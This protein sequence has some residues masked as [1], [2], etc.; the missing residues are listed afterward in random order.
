MGDLFNEFKT[1]DKKVYGKGDEYNFD[2]KVESLKT[3]N[4]DRDDMKAIEQLVQILAYVP[5]DKLNLAS[6]II[7][8]VE[9]KTCIR[10]TDITGMRDYYSGDDA[11]LTIQAEN[12]THRTQAAKLAEYH[13]QYK[14]Y[15]EIYK[16]FL[17]AKYLISVTEYAEASGILAQFK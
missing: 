7:S 1:E 14:F 13:T 12:C 2:K 16:P 6:G 4:I 5:A 11:S 10:D 8:A 9:H 15:N 17:K 3:V